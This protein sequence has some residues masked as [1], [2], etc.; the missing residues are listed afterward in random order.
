MLTQNNSKDLFLNPKNEKQFLANVKK[1]VNKIDELYILQE[2]NISNLKL[3]I[4]M[5]LKK[6]LIIMRNK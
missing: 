5:N 4:I 2:N 1:N 6:K 3:I